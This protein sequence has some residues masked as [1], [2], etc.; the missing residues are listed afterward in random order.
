MAG[1]GFPQQH[2]RLNALCLLNSTNIQPSEQY[3]RATV[4]FRACR[5]FRD[6]LMFDPFF[7]HFHHFWVADG[8]L[9]GMILPGTP[10]ENMEEICF[11]GPVDLVDCSLR[12]SSRRQHMRVK[13]EHLRTAEVTQQASKAIFQEDPLCSIRYPWLI[14]HLM[15][16]KQQN[17][18]VSTKVL[19]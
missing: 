10:S 14:G 2:G 12:S 1:T 19:R 9:Q 16:H 18:S 7:G 5:R 13:P 4:L 17:H 3:L 6:V 11:R 8:K 15:Q